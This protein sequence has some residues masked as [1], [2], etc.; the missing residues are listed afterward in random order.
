MEISVIVCTHNP[1]PN[2][3]RRVLDALQAQTLPK[4]QW[5]LL[6]I[7]N[8][9]KEPLAEKWELSW[10]PNARHIREDELGLTLA[11]LRGIKESAGGLLVF[12]DDDNL[13]EA[14]YLRTALN[15]MTEFPQIAVFGGQ[16][17]GDFETPPPSWAEPYLPMLAL[18]S[19]ERDSWSNDPLRFGFYPC[20][21]G[22]CVTR[23]IALKYSKS[24]QDDV[25]RRSLDRRGVELTS[26]G[27]DDIAFTAGSL[28]L[29]VGVFCR[30]KLTHLIP[31]TRLTED[32]LLR[33]TQGLVYCGY[34]TRYA[35]GEAGQ[36]P[37]RS[38]RWRLGMFRR[39][40]RMSR[41]ERRFTQ[42]Q[43]R[44]ETAAWQTI[45]KLEQDKKLLSQGG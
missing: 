25:W 29:G 15:L 30:L 23:E 33:L 17:L 3:L 38:L 40:L 21:A 2:Y 12:V 7:D 22:L 16:V 35:R 42:A 41:I 1:R 9:S 34:I 11:R 5:E 26:G 4:Q 6:L 8:A 45:E 13:L 14:G 43:V 37:N 20:G 10:H 24:L 27:D 31:A 39:S 28:G 36:R 32:Y 18:R 19:C 44:G